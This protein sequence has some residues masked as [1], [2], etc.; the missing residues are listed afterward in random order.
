MLHSNRFPIPV[1]RIR[2]AGILLCLVLAQGFAAR[3]EAQEESTPKQE[4]EALN[5]SETQDQ[6]IAEFRKYAAEKLPSLSEAKIDLIVK[7]VDENNDGIVSASEFA[8]RV[9]IFRDVARGPEPWHEDLETARA[10]A[11][12]TGKPLLIYARAD[13]CGVCKQ[14]EKDTLP[15]ESIQSAL[16]GFVLFRLDIDDDQDATQELGIDAVPTMT[17]ETSDGESLKSRGSKQ[18]AALIE[19]LNDALASEEA[20]DSP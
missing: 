10:V 9:S 5:A 20:D 7:R 14:F 18:E 19:W 6:T 17:I 12:D 2:L 15:L 1:A 13:W 11:K 16:T 8:K 4:G 3:V